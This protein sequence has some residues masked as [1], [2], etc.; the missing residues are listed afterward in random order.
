MKI[1]IDDAVERKGAATGNKVSAAQA[2]LW[3]EGK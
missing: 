3:T 2:A 1:E